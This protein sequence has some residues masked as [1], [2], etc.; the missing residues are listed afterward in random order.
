[1]QQRKKLQK[2]KRIVRK[3]NLSYKKV[4]EEIC[5]KEDR[6][7]VCNKIM[8]VYSDYEKVCNRCLCGDTSE[9]RRL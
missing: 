2:I 6:C 9:R 3:N 7:A 1:M 8:Y 5:L 4:V